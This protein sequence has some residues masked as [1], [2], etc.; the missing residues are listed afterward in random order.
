M[1]ERAV[2]PEI[3]EREIFELDKDERWQ[4]RL[5]EARARREIALREK[6]NMEQPPERRRKPWEEEGQAA[7]PEPIEPLIQPEDEKRLDFADRMKTL[8]KTIGR[9][10]DNG[11]PPV[12]GDAMAAPARPV[13]PLAKPMSDP[14]AAEKPDASIA[15]RY[16]EALA[17]DF[18]PVQ[19]FVPTVPNYSEPS[20][21]PSL[22]RKAPPPK[23]TEPPKTA[24]AVDVPMAD[25][26][27]ARRRTRV[28]A[29][30]LAGICLL[31][32]L[33]FTSKAPPMEIGPPIPYQ[34]PRFGLEPALGIMRPMNAIPRRT[35][36]WEWLP[37]LNRAT[38]GPLALPLE[39]PADMQRSIGPLVD[40]APGEPGFGEMN[41]TALTAAPGRGDVGAFATPVPDR[42]PGPSAPPTED[43]AAI[44]PVSRPETP[45]A[46]VEQAR[47]VWPEPL[48]DLRVTILVPSAGDPAEAEAIAEN[49][50]ARGHDLARIKPVDLKINE[51][52]VRY[53]HGRDRGEAARL[54][55]AYDA[56]LRDFT[57][58][59]PTPKDGTV[60]IWLSGNGAQAA[61]PVAPRK[62]ATTRTVEALPPQP[63]IIIIQ[64]QQSFLDRLTDAIGGGHVGGSFDATS[65]SD[66]APIPMPT[67]PAAGA[68]A[69][70][71]TTNTTTS[72]TGTTTTST[73]SSSG[74]SNNG[75]GGGNGNSK[76]GS[77]SSGS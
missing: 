39:R 68:S 49:V 5:A 64:R 52:N 66:G 11:G 8:R 37:E 14:P 18:E 13:E 65:S 3:P 12:D 26:A 23:V 2:R 34:E 21:V 42:L 10:G 27:P 71:G 60:E 41:W 57:S 46:P 67:T 24:P 51:R 61:A 77:G 25:R 20:S 30:L 72:T 15:D 44:V 28:P 43:A 69:T 7:P 59:R 73:N 22:L 62:A 4:A 48:S 29:M 74:S 16:L 31:S 45:V 50:L 36:S 32:L 1:A 70:V 58:F 63:R 55:D 76:S 33:P 35:M 54:A 40:V 6:A 9:H 75:P 53:F 19:P 17:P 38:A 56:R 47:A